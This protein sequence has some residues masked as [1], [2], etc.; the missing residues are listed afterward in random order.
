MTLQTGKLVTEIGRFQLEDEQ[1]RLPAGVT[2][3]SRSSVSAQSEAK[4]LF[5]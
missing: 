4:C 1:A 2:N 3:F 5:I